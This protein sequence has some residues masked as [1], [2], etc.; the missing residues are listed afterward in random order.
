MKIFNNT[1]YL[2]KIIALLFGAQTTTC[3]ANNVTDEFDTFDLNNNGEITFSELSTAMMRENGK[4]INDEFIEGDQ[5]NNKLLSF[6]EA[7]KLGGSHKEYQQADKNNNGQIDLQEF[8]QAM[9]RGLRDMFDET[10][11]NHDNIVVFSEFKTAV[12]GK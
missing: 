7:Q 3:W 8:T 2:V 10:D 6:S 1:I 5:D 4:S 11:L 12:Q 9:L